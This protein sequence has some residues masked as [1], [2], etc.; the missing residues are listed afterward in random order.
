MTAAPDRTDW[1]RKTYISRSAPAGKVVRAVLAVL[2]LMVSGSE[3]LVTFEHGDAVP[4]F[5]RQLVDWQAP[6][7]LV[8]YLRSICCDDDFAH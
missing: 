8:Q 5:A 1:R 4:G 6:F 3:M 7:D 2:I